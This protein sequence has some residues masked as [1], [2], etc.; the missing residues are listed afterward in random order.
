MPNHTPPKPHSTPT[1]DP[2]DPEPGLPPLAPED[3]LTAPEIPDDPEYD[4]VVEPED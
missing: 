1:Q 2:S 4:R 3:G